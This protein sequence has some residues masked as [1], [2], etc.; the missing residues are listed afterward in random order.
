M[1]FADFQQT[2]VERSS[3]RADTGL[4]L[5]LLREAWARGEGKSVRLLGLGVSLPQP[6]E[7]TEEHQ[8]SL[9]F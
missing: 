6:E 4:F 8:L 5:A 7:K 3:R 2:T 9:A 1:K